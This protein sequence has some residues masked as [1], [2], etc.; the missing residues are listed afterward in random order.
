M[1][2]CDCLLSGILNHPA[3]FRL[4]PGS[5][6]G[7]RYR[8]H[9]LVT[10]RERSFGRSDS[11]IDPRPALRVVEDCWARGGSGRNQIQI[12]A[13]G[14]NVCRS[15]EQAILLIRPPIA[16]APAPSSICYS[17]ARSARNHD[18][19]GATHR[20]PR[21]VLC[22][23]AWAASSWPRVSVISSHRRNALRLIKESI[24]QRVTDASQGQSGSSAVRHSGCTGSPEALDAGRRASTFAMR[25]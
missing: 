5:A 21:P 20:S 18:I 8:H 12:A 4:W 3:D 24:N 10:T 23:P 1:R 19:Y 22:F 15:A 7:G 6:A 13:R 17:H 9:R 11:G 2:L 25:P 16:P 14:R